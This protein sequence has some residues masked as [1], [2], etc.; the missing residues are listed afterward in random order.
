MDQWNET[1]VIEKGDVIIKEFYTM[2]PVW[3]EP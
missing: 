1:I 2:E 3:I